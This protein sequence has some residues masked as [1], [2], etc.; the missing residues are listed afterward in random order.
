MHY[1][2]AI[3]Q[4]VMRRVKEREKG[5]KYQIGALLVG[6]ICIS[7]LHDGKEVEKAHMQ[8]CTTKRKKEMSIEREL[9][10]AEGGLL[11]TEPTFSDKLLLINL[12]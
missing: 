4:T 7:L 5:R 11:I 9:S 8:R 1:S 10:W 12:K 6:G 2:Q 3:I